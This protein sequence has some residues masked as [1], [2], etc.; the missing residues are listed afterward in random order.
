MTSDENGYY[1]EKRRDEKAEKHAK[2]K[3]SEEIAEKNN[4]KKWQYKLK[5]MASQ[6]A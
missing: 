3:K 1:R 2:K 4:L 6:T 5:A